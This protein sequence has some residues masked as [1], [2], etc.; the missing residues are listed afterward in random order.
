MGSQGRPDVV[1]VDGCKA[2][3]FAVRLWG[4][5]KFE[6]IKRDCFGKLVEYFKDADLI[7][8]DIPIGLPEGPGGRECDGLARRACRRPSAVFPTPCRATAEQAFREP[9]NYA[10]MRRVEKCCSEKGMSEQGCGITAKIGEVDQVMGSR[11]SHLSPVVRE[12][13][14][15]VCFWALNS[16]H[17]LKFNKKA[18]LRKGYDERMAILREFEPL[19]DKIAEDASDKYMRKEVGWDDI[20]DALAAAVTGYHGYDSLRTL[21]PSPPC[22][23]KGL[24]MEMVYWV[25]SAT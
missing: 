18:S 7:L 13:H 9:K 2:G 5:G 3:W 1:G 24:P 4:Q 20:A 8:V 10:E 6:T 19:T 17:P 16:E 15:E 25:P 12:I 11:T 23:A 22:D 14:P 21:P